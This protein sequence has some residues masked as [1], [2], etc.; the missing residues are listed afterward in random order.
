MPGFQIG[1]NKSKRLSWERSKI[2]D[3]DRGCMWEKGGPERRRSTLCA[4]GTYSMVSRVS[5]RKRS[6]TYGGNSRTK[7]E[8]LTEKQ[9]FRGGENG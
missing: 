7:R 3:T 4:R 6:V 9:F 8:G 2:E 5:S 1:E